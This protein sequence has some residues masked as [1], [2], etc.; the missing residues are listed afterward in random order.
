MLLPKGYDDHPNSYYPTIYQEG[1]FGLG[2][3]FTFST[4]GTPVSAA[5]RARLANFNRE[6]G[7][8]FYQSWTADN[9]PRMISVTF[10]HPT[11]FYD[12]SYAVNSVNQGP[13]GDAL[14]K[15][16]IPYLGSH[17]RM[18]A[19]PPYARVLTGG[20]TG[21]WESLATQVF[22]PDFFGGTWTLYPDP[23]DFRR[24][25]LSNAY[26]DDSMYHEP[27]H[28]WVDAPRYMERK[29]DGQPETTMQQEG[30]LENV[31]GDHNR[32]GEQ[33]EAWD[34][35]F[36]P[37]GD[38]GYP[39]PMWDKATGKI[40]KG[41]LQYWRDHGYDLSYNIRTNWPTLGPKLRGKIHV[42]VGDE[43]YYYLNLAV[44]LLDD[45]MKGLAEPTVRLRVSVR[46]SDEG[47]RL[48]THLER[49]PGSL[50]E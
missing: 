32:S 8:E 44:Y 6:T 29:A 5:A 25:Q 34:A 7:Y 50:D 9:F 40:D 45:T 4:D 23:V 11:P 19:K 20:S 30:Q 26:E 18:I 46:P 24:F 37:V 17:F 21:G 47:A 36:S 42:Y 28:T 2:N 15:E 48:A 31:L 13:Y 1:H 35:A 39:K 41:V 14:T 22:Y 12:D 49:R 33:F 43:D 38:D 27:G 16:L 3:P 10:Q